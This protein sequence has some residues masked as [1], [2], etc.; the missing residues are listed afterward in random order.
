MDFY[1]K[2]LSELTSEEWEKI[3]LKCGKCCMCKYS[4]DGLIHFSNHICH[5]FDL[6]K[7]LCSC[8][9]ERFEV[10]KGDCKKVS[11]ELLENDLGL[12][13]PSCAYR[14]L[15]EGRGLPV[16]HP[17]LTKDPKSVEKAGKTLKSLP[18]FSE[19]AKDDALMDLLK[20]VS[21]KR[22][23]RDDV[24]QKA[25]EIHDKFALR[26]LES[27]PYPNETEKPTE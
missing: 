21:Q 12:L 19:K 2:P 25:K 17:L 18:V 1:E 23:S 6:N 24:I 13:P 10:A 16:Y 4:G 27:Y 15:Y 20:Q 8:Y 26:W 11:L 7:G 22:L 3:C 9:E 14:S 5:Y